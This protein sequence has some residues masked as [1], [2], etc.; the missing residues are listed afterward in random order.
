[1]RTAKESTPVHETRSELLGFG[2]VG[3]LD[4]QARVKRSVKAKVGE[5]PPP[6]EVDN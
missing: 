2:S 5:K 3:G 1:M 6:V 4:R